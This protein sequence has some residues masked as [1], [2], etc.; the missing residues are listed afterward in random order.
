M[1]KNKILLPILFGAFLASGC[2]LLEDSVAAMKNL[3]CTIGSNQDCDS[4]TTVK[5]SKTYVTKSKSKYGSEI[6]YLIEPKYKLVP[7]DYRNPYSF[8]FVVIVKDEKISDI[9]LA[10]GSIITKFNVGYLGLFYDKNGKKIT[11]AP[12]DWMNFLNKAYNCKKSRKGDQNLANTYPA[13][14]AISRIIKNN[15]YNNYFYIKQ[16]SDVDLFESKDDL[17]ILED[18]LDLSEILSEIQNK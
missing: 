7:T 4:T 9:G 3:N 15:S 18:T 11:K 14:Y 16:I 17:L 1:M 13:D 10:E 6:Y 2:N 12:K 8:F 5:S